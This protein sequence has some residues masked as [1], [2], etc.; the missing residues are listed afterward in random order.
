MFK[1]DIQ[2]VEGQIIGKNHDGLI[3]L[4]ALQFWERREDDFSSPEGIPLSG[5]ARPFLEISSEDSRKLNLKFQNE[6]GIHNFT[7]GLELPFDHIVING[8][9]MPIYEEEMANVANFL[10]SHRVRIGDCVNASLY[11]S[12]LALRNTGKVEV[13][14]EDNL[15]FTAKANFESI[16][17]PL[18]TVSPYP[19]QEFGI[20]WLASMY[21]QEVGA[22]LGDQ[23]GLGKTIQLIGLALYCL[24]NKPG[25]KVLV[26]TP[27][28]LIGNWEREFKKFSPGTSVCTHIGSGRAFT[29]SALVKDDIILMS[30]D[31]LIRDIDLVNRIDWNLVIC[32]EAHSLKNP[33]S[34][35]RIAVQSLPCN[36]KILAT[37]TP[38]E[39]HLID[40]WSLMDL[41]RPGI[42]GDRRTFLNLYENEIADAEEMGEMVKPL[43]LRRLV[44]DELKEL[45]PLIEIDEPLDCDFNFA[46]AYEEVRTGALDG[47]FESPVIARIQKLRM[48][49]CYP[50]LVDLKYAGIH[51]SK[52]NR[53][54]EILD[55]I[56][57]GNDEKVLI[58]TSYRDSID[59]LLQVIN[60]EYPNSYCG[61]ID[62][63]YSREDRDQIIAEF[64][65]IKGFAVLIANPKAAGEGLNITAANHVI[66]FNREW[67][68]Q[69]ENQ[70]TARSRRPGQTR[71]VFAHRFY[72]RDT[73]EEVISERLLE[74][75][76]LANSALMPTELEAGD[77]SI[78]LA[79]SISP[80]ARYL[81]K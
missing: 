59:Y 49:C 64:S 35:R 18:L 75:S 20:R 4:T 25:S 81:E 65:D 3:R 52:L 54:L 5:M 74:K 10:Q 56:I 11:V 47:E 44:R 80:A 55:G 28:S 8:L 19:Y 50:P 40:L 13:R 58:F 15:G 26:I 12:L 36:T 7:Q 76:N 39:N 73:I 34:L 71:T 6:T 48:F 9:W 33:D 62:G 67:N 77:K 61:V 2:V 66:H 41:I 57:Q 70:A 38:V 30:Y 17:L 69:K 37:G 14:I 31:V 51:D 42:M 29:T 53:L 79:L 43:I 63:R 22:L 60:G 68:P 1:G 45:P 72:Y 23:M 78:E 32:D 24:E 46:T 16:K 21:E 27:S